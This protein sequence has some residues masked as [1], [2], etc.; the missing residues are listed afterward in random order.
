MSYLEQKKSREATR[1]SK[2]NSAITFA[3][4]GL[5]A[6]A[7]VLTWQGT[8]DMEWSKTLLV[9]SGKFSYSLLTFSSTIGPLIGTRFLPNWLNA[10]LKTGWHG[11][12]AG[13][14]LVLGVIHGLFTMDGP[15]SMSIPEVLVPGLALQPRTL[16]A[17]AGTIG[18]WLMLAAYVTY[19]LRN[20][21][22]MKA[23]RILHLLS[24][25][26][27]IAI[28]LHSIWLGHG[29]VDAGYVVSSVA[30]GLALVVRLGTLARR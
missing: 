6:L 8:L 29:R 28:T 18:L 7:W 12:T 5:L 17:A 26:A 13:F 20:R 1:G 4:L 30:V 15:G 10:S 11:V 24:Y 2:L 21:I 14:A 16:T 25:P 27:F 23:A 22:G 19:A 3:L 9:Q